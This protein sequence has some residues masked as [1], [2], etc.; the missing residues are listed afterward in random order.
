VKANVGAADRTMRIV[1]G[2]AL[3][4]L[5]VLGE[6]LGLLRWLGLIGAVP[7]L[8]GLFGYCPVYALFGFATCPLKKA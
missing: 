6:G 5:L 1:V 7:L 8:T 2:I 4:G 3:L